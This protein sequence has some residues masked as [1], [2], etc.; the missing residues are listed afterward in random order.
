MTSLTLCLVSSSNQTKELEIALVAYSI[1]ILL[2]PVQQQKGI[3]E[4]QLFSFL[5]LVL[6]R[7]MVKPPFLRPFLQL[8][9]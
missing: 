9:L 7:E 3:D 8:F 1:I 6:A 5:A 4:C 2:S